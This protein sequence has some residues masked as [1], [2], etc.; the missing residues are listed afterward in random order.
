MGVMTRRVWLTVGAIGLAMTGIGLAPAGPAGAVGAAAGAGP[1]A[2]ADPGGYVALGDS[3]TAGPLIPDQLADPLGCLRSD[4]DYPHVVAAAL[5][6]AAFRDVS[7][8][9]ADTGDM[10]SP[11]GV[12]PG[13]NPPQLDALSPSTTLVTLGIGGNDIGFSEIIQRCLTL[14]PWET[15]CRDTYASGGTDEL[16][17]RIAAAAPQVAGVLAGIRTRAPQ[18]RVLVVGYPAIVPHAG[19]GC[20]PTMPIGWDDVAYLR[21]KHREL[22]AMLAAQA[23]AGGATYVDTYTPSIGHDVCAPLGQ[24]WVEPIVPASAAAPV[25]PNARGMRGMAAAVLAAA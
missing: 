10:T 1:A 23:A 2:E 6:P 22:N 13:P 24:R 7:C 12:T 19:R 25:H 11:Q 17:R 15:P 16:S 3:Y 9:G 14:V 21:A 18:A 4:R 8:S 5:A 20:W